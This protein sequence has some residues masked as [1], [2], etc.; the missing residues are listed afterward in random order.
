MTI[1]CLLRVFYV[2]LR[3]LIFVI[4]IEQGPECCS[5]TAISFHY[6]SGNNM[7]LMEYVIY[8]LKPFGILTG[9]SD[10]KQAGFLKRLPA[11]DP[12]IVRSLKLP[13]L[14]SQQLEKKQQPPAQVSIAPGVAAKGADPAAPAPPAI[15]AAAAPPVAWKPTR[16]SGCDVILLCVLIPFST[17]LAR[18]LLRYD[19][20]CD[21]LCNLRSD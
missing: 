4:C 5:D 15:A 6:M 12:A 3:I 16:R 20:L 17:S 7:Y 11:V 10:L 21:L 2:N 18:T 8:H 14:Q 19:S 9:L 13:H 1:A